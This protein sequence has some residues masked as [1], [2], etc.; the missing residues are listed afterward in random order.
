MENFK[1]IS[2]FD[3]ENVQKLIGKDWMLISAGK[4]GEG[5]NTMTASWGSMGVLWNKPVCTVYIRPQRFTYLFA[6][7]NEEMTMCFF[8]EDKRDVLRFCGSHSGRDFDKAKECS[9]TPVS[10]SGGK[11]VI[12]EEARLALICRK[13]YASDIKDECFIDKSLLS[14]YAEKDY[15]RQYICEITKVLVRA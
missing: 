14:N 15:H 1:E 10:V 6:E 13:L 5:Y 7:A 3:I 4:L 9:L 12:F 8:D 11:A 2:V